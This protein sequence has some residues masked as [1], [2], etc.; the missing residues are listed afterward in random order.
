MCSIEWR[1]YRWPWVTPNHSNQ[2]N[3]Y[4][5]RCLSYIQVTTE[6]S[7][8]ICGLNTASRILLTNGRG[9]VTWSSL[10]FKAPNHISGITE[11]I[12]S[13]NF[14]Y[15]Y[16]LYQVLPKVAYHPVCGRGYDHVTVFKFCRLPRCTASCGFVSDSWYLLRYASEQTDIQT[17]RAQ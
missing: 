3:F 7:N 12:E 5:L 15:R 14:S 9:H 2:H 1:H 17:R 4:I 8:L 16:R 13:S 11:A 10:N 6:I